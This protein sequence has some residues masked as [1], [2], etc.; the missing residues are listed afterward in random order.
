MTMLK[1]KGRKNTKKRPSQHGDS[2]ISEVN[3]MFF[4]AAKDLYT[5]N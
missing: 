5:K 1:I 2:P 3:Q 4:P